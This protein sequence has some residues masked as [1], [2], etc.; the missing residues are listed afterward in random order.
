PRI[1]VKQAQQRGGIGGNWNACMK[2][3]NAPLVQYLFQDD[4]WDS[5]YLQKSVEALT[6]DETLALTAANHFYRDDQ[7][8]DIGGRYGEIKALRDGMFRGKGDGKKFLMDWIAQG[9]APN[10]IGEPSFVLMRRTCME[11]A[12]PFVEDMPQ[13]LDVEYWTRML[14][15]GGWYGIRENLGTFRVH[16]DGASARNE[17][18]GQGMFDRFR[19]FQKLISTLP[20]GPERKAVIGARNQS[21]EE[22]IDK[23]F[24]RVKGGKKVTG[25]GGKKTRALQWSDYPILLGGVVRYI[26]RTPWRMSEHKKPAK[27]PS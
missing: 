22:M 20:R 8:Q 17:R 11:Q 12:G 9:L 19:C 2:H 13:F 4:I 25:G 21:L 7:G 26:L 15:T 27:Q 24:N 16:P 3:G 23:F 18:S 6:S 10:L 14:L 5:T 1:V